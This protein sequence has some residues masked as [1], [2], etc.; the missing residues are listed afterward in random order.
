MKDKPARVG[1]IFSVALVAGVVGILFFR[2]LLLGFAGFAM[3]LGST[4]E[5]WLGSSYSI[6]EKEARSRV[7]ASVSSMTWEEVKRLIVGS[8]AIKLSP[9]SSATGAEAFRGVLLKTSSENHSQVLEFVKSRCSEDVA[10][11]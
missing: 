5:F 4:A 1:L 7:G 10:C 8:Q 2:N 6:D 9:L 3:I 11:E